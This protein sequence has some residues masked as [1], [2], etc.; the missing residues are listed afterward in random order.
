[1]TWQYRTKDNEFGQKQTFDYSQCPP[2]LVCSS[3]YLSYTNTG[4][5]EECS[6]CRGVHEET[7]D[8]GQT[9]MELINEHGF[10]DYVLVENGEIVRFASGKPMPVCPQCR[11]HVM[12]NRG[13]GCLCDSCNHEL[14]VEFEHDY[15]DGFL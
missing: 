13:N 9:T 1:M 4:D 15:T 12:P 5:G 6:D 8:E 7:H 3:C 2:L 10:N 14:M 11:C